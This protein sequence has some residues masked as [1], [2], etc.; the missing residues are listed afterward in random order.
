M[1]R[2]GAG[3]GGGVD[4]DDVDVAP[5]FEEVGEGGG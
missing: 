4:D 3:W 5:G 2:N 1:G